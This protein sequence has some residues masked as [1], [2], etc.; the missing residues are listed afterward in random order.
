MS[1]PDTQDLRPLVRVATGIAAIEAHGWRVV[2]EDGDPVVI[3]QGR[4]STTFRRRAERE[5]A[6]H[7]SP[8]RDEVVEHHAAVEGIW[9]KLAGMAIARNAKTVEQAMAMRSVFETALEK[10]SAAFPHGPHRAGQMALN[11]MLTT[12][13]LHAH[14]E[15]PTHD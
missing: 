10:A 7:L 5:I 9:P 14:E 2:I 6:R 3:E 12:F 1:T 13:G 4:P 11:K 15:T 8:I